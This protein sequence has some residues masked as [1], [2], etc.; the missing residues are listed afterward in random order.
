M[1]NIKKITGTISLLLFICVYI[2]QFFFKF[3]QKESY[4][5]H[6]IAAVF[7]GGFLFCFIPNVKQ[8]S[9]KSTENRKLTI[10]TIVSI[11]IILILIPLTLFMGIFILKDRKYYFIS[12]LIILEI[13]IP[14]FL[15]FEDKKPKATEIVLISMLCAIATAGRGAFFMLP[16]FKPLLAIVII[17]GVCFGG[18]S[19]FLVGAVSGFLSN[20]FFGQGSWTPWQ[21][22]CYGL[23]G[24]IAGLLFEKG[25]LKRT[26]ISLCSYG[27]L[28]TVIIFGGIINIQSFLA[29]TPQPT[30]ELFISTLLA[31]LPFDL[32]HATATV[33]FLYFLAEPM[34][35]KIERIKLKYGI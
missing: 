25:I 32:I 5:I 7:L 9:Y 4:I 34:I 17:A 15:T 28:S 16:Q 2:L 29:W 13:M 22:F 23:V 31:G 19:G 26:K 14:F 24:L 18:E 20:F 30:W 11:F 8:K 10:R 1:K 21:M 27:A 6:I 12:L 35:E 33:Y 3:T